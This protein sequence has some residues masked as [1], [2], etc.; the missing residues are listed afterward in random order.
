MCVTHR[1]ISIK[2]KL[3]FKSVTIIRN[4]ETSTH[5]NQ[6]PNKIKVFRPAIEHML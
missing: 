2:E 5:S 6:E 4:R 3:Q 1:G